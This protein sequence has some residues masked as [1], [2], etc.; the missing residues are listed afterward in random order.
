MLLFI[1]SSVH[2]L[3]WHVQVNCLHPLSYCWRMGRRN[4]QC[5][6]QPAME[7]TCTWCPLV[8]GLACRGREWRWGSLH[9]PH[10]LMNYSIC[11]R[12]FVGFSS[13]PSHLTNPSCHPL[14]TPQILCWGLRNMA[15]YELQSITRPSIEFECGGERIISPTMKNLR[16]NP[17]FDKPHLVFD[18]V[19]DGL[20]LVKIKH[21]LLFSLK[22]TNKIW[23]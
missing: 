7:E 4:C 9:H 23:L 8:C 14:I 17:N 20:W 6:H 2:I 11:V 18:V 3:L 5:C 16:I 1:C 19:S 22:E 13:G 10:N 12:S 15:T 21:Q